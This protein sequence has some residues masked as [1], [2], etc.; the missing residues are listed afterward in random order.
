LS[1]ALD[2]V[3]STDAGDDGHSGRST[4]GPVLLFTRHVTDLNAFV[5]PS[6]RQAQREASLARIRLLVKAGQLE[7]HWMS[8]EE[9][10]AYRLEPQDTRAITA[11]RA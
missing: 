6:R 10:V 9:T 1:V 8:D 11:T 2:A 4:D 7:I 3:K 5:R